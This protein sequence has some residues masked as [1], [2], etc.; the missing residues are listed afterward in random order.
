M[1]QV[2]GSY[3]EHED[4]SLNQDAFEGID[5]AILSCLVS[6]LRLNYVVLTCIYIE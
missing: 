6:F 5:K 3:T 2:N 4:M 1:L